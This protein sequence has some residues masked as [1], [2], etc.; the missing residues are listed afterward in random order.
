M[1]E[2]IK[3]GLI[4][5]ENYNA[6]LKHPQFPTIVWNWQ[7]GCVQALAIENQK[8]AIAVPFNTTRALN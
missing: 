6:L 8:G 5:I 3:H 1:Y 7:Y 2:V 4:C